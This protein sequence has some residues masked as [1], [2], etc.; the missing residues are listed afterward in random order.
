VDIIKLIVGLLILIFG[1]DFL[2]KGAVALAVRMKVSMIVIGLTVVSFATSAPEM[3]VSVYAALSGHPDMAIG[4]VIGSNIANISLVLGLTAIIFPLSFKQRL[5]KFDVPVMLIVT[6]LFIAFLYTDSS[7]VRWEGM[8]FIAFLIVF[9]VYLIA[10]SRKEDKIN[11]STTE[12]QLSLVKLLSFLTL[13]S[14]CLYIGSRLLVDSASS[15][16]SDL[17]VTDRVISVSI[18]AFGTSVPE[19]AASIIAAYKKEK[20]MSLGNLIG[21][22]IFNILAV[23]GVTSII[24][25]IHVVESGLLSNDIWWM[26]A[27]S[28]ILFPL[29]FL[30]HKGHIGRIEGFI[31][32]SIYVCC[33]Y[34]LF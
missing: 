12:N 21:S 29:M 7:L 14:V 18:V 11:E 30:F 31:L 32:L 2:V 26:A 16:A 20:E 6:A 13:G 17:G 4:N 22:N 25:P 23:L 34:L 33:M 3:I 15:L 8:I 9:T 24:H 5:Y 10:R 1:G 19:L 28:L 27:V